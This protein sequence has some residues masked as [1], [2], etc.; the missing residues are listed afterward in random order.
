MDLLLKK[1]E[2]LTTGELCGKM[3]ESELR[4]EGKTYD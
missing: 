3:C 2:N 1:G 4:F